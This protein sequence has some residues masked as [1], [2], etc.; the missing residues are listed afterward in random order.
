MTILTVPL[1]FYWNIQDQTCILSYF[2]VKSSRC[3][4]HLLSRTLA[5][6]H[7]SL[8]CYSCFA[9]ASSVQKR[10][11]WGSF[12]VICWFICSLL[13]S[14]N[15]SITTNATRTEGGLPVVWASNWDHSFQMEFFKPFFFSYD[16]LTYINTF[17]YRRTYA[18]RLLPYELCFHNSSKMTFYICHFT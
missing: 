3:D 16:V 9:V 8:A 6:R 13:L 18:I 15:D 11:V 12:V 4:V 17:R 1:N 10:S 2:R 7:Y 14:A 5:L